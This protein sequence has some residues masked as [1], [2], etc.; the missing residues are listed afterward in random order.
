LISNG[1]SLSTQNLHLKT[2]R[3]YN[4]SGKYGTR[5]ALLYK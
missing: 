4:L 2:N 1:N 3:P 5:F